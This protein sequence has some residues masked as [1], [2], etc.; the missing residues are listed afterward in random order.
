MF[1]KTNRDK[2]EIIQVEVLEN[3]KQLFPGGPVV[4]IC[5]PI[6]GGCRLSPWFGKVPRARETMHHASE[7]SPFA[8]TRESP[9]TAAETQHSRE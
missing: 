7:S 3:H 2:K 5:L 6:L 8:A 9:H 1:R 4:K